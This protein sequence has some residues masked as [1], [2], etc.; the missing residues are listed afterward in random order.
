MSACVFVILYQFTEKYHNVS[1]NCLCSS[2]KKQNIG[3]QQVTVESTNQVFVTQERNIII[4]IYWFG[5][6]IQQ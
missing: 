1:E 5:W 3:N 6:W 4:L 2:E